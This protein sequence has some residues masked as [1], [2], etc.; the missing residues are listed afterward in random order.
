MEILIGFAA[1]FLA[2]A[3]LSMMML[4]KKAMGIMP[5]LSMIGM[6]AKVT[7]QPRPVDWLI[8]FAVGTFLYGLLIALIAPATPLPYWAEGLIVGAIGWMVAGL[9][10][11][12]AAGKGF[13]RLGDRPV[14]VF[15]VDDGSRCPGAVS[16]PDLR[17]AGL[18]AQPLLAPSL[19]IALA[20]GV[21]LPVAS[22]ASAAFGAAL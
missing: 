9:V 8:H 12:P 20:T 19:V 11:M 15:H 4:A 14:R 5:E 6:L 18:A 7:G 16:R 2:T 3:I 21:H 13:F 1:G 17:L 22:D 10:L